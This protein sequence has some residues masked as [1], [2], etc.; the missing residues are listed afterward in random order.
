MKPALHSHRAGPES[1]S[2]DYET[3]QVFLHLSPIHQTSIAISYCVS[4]PQSQ[5]TSNQEAT[6]CSMLSPRLTTILLVSL[7]FKQWQVEHTTW[8]QLSHLKRPHQFDVNALVDAPQF[9]LKEEIQIRR[10]RPCAWVPISQIGTRVTDGSTRLIRL[11]PTSQPR[12]T[13]KAPS[14]KLKRSWF[15]DESKSWPF[16]R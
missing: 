16:C 11:K 1:P 6:T 13:W 7:Q 3:G 15:F 2:P 5:T 4:R 10:N 14:W 9:D 8:G 12:I